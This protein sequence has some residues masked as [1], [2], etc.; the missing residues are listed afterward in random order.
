VQK[1]VESIPPQAE[2]FPKE[3]AAHNKQFLT[4]CPGSLFTDFTDILQYAAFKLLRLKIK[5]FML[6]KRLTAYAKQ[7][8]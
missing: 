3:V 2:V 7:F 6:L 1:T 8:T 5:I 4:A